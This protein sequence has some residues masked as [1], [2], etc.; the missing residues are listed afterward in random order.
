M[1][2]GLILSSVANKEPFKQQVFWLVALIFFSIMTI[3]AYYNR[4]KNVIYLT[5]GQ[6]VLELLAE[7]PDNKTVIS[8]I[9]KI[10]QSMREFYKTKYSSFDL[11]TPYEIKLNQLKWLKEIRALT[12]KEYNELLDNTK[13]ENIIGINRPNFED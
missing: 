4:N 12:D 13:T 2:V 1:Y 8:F 5:G 10:H 6:K 9:E 11:D 3:A 7:K